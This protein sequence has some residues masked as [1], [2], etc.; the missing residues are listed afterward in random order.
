MWFCSVSS[1][2]MIHALCIWELQI[3]IVIFIPGLHKCISHDRLFCHCPI[4][5][6]L[7]IFVILPIL[8]KL[9]CCP[10]DF[11]WR[12]AEPTRCNRFCDRCTNNIDG[13]VWDSSALA[14]LQQSHTKPFIYNHVQREQSLTFETGQRLPS[15]EPSPEPILII[16]NYTPKTNFRGLRQPVDKLKHYD[17]QC[18]TTILVSGLDPD[19]RWGPP[20]RESFLHFQELIIQISWK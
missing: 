4:C 14:M 10:C 6:H 2:V 20:T 11:K 19:P 9:M 18:E 7:Q 17:D 15:T 8:D 1:L 12:L 13:L 5:S 16:G 3:P